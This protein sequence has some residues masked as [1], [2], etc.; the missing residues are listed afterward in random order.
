MF[1]GTGPFTIYTSRVFLALYFEVFLGPNCGYLESSLSESATKICPPRSV[2]QDW[3]DAAKLKSLDFFF[4][5]FSRA[6]HNG[7]VFS[8]REV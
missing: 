5:S 1:R 7:D 4:L 2:S 3:R 8:E 6:C